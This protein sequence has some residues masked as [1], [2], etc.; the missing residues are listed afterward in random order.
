MKKITLLLFFIFF[1]VA[2]PINLSKKCL[3]S[4]EINST[5]KPI[6]WEHFHLGMQ[7]KALFLQC[8]LSNQTEQKKN[9][10][11]YSTSPLIEEF[12]SINI[13][14]KSTLFYQKD[15]LYPFITI[16]LPPH[17]SKKIFFKVKANYSP[18]DFTLLFDTFEN[19]LTRNKQELLF[20]FYLYGFI[21]ALA[22]FSFLTALYLKD[23]AFLFYGLYLFTVLLQQSDYLG[24]NKFIFPKEIQT[25]LAKTVTLKITLLIIFG[26][27][28]A[29]NFLRLQRFKKIFY[30]YLLIISIAIITLL[31]PQDSALTFYSTIL[32]GLFLIFF[33]LLSALYVY[34]KGVKEARFYL[35]GFFIAFLAYL[36]MI[37]DALGVVSIIYKQHNLLLIASSFEALFLLLAFAD[38]YAILRRQKDYLDALLLQ[39]LQNKKDQIEQE[40]QRKT[41][42]LQIALGEKELLLQELNHR[43]KNNLQ[44]IL[45]MLNLQ[46]QNIPPTCWEYF[47]KLDQRISAIAHTYSFL[48]ESKELKEVDMK[49]YLHTILQ[50]LSNFFNKKNIQIVEEIHLK[51]PLKEAVYV[52]IIVNELVTNAF[53][54]AFDFQEKGN[55]TIK[56][57]QEKKRK[58]LIVSDSGKGFDKEKATSSLGLKIVYLLATRQLNGTITLHSNNQTKCIIK[59]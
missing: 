48:I 24:L 20:N 33:N 55:I 14:Q 6:P 46:K 42:E 58:I 31:L 10:V 54:H 44:I 56:L 7:K 52:G 25:L 49:K 53:K 1:A 21:S 19:F 22:I 59:F 50:D 27:F 5:F 51:L 13:P 32:L 11:L 16:T 23:I 41:K 34:N 30:I 37:L 40:V 28:F 9:F 29:I 39:E 26:S 17:S 2:K 38:K 15:I 8:T 45:S 36:A 4:Y 18:L 47:N 35:L 43:V 12:R 3:Y 57:F